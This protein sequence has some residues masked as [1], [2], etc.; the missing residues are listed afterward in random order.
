MCSLTV[1]SSLVLFLPP[2]EGGHFAFVL[3][4]NL[5]GLLRVRNNGMNGEKK[6]KPSIVVDFLTVVNV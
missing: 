1:R 5:S 3:L 2:S 6:D 4:L